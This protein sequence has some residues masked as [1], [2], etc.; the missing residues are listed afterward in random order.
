MENECH[1]LRLK[2]PDN[3]VLVEQIL[4]QFV[5]DLATI[6]NHY[7]LPSIIEQTNKNIQLHANLVNVTGGMLALDKFK[8]YY[9]ELFFDSEG[10]PHLHTMSDR[11][12]QI[13]VRD[14]LSGKLVPIKQLDP[15]TPHKNLGYLLVPDGDQTPMF[16]FILSHVQD[17][18]AK[19]TNSILWPHEITLSYRS[20]L[21]PQVRYRLAA[22][23][24]TYE[25][26]DFMMKLIYP[27]L[28]HASSLPST[29]P[30][31]IASAPFTYAGLGFEHFYDIQG[32]E[33]L[34]LFMMHLRRND[35]TGKMIY[36]ALQIMQQSVGSEKEFYDM[37]YNKYELYLPPSWLKH[38]C[39]YIHSRDVSFELTKKVAFTKQRMHDQFIMDV[40]T[41]YFTKTQLIQINKIRIHLKV[42]RLSDITDI[43]GKYILPNILRG[44]NFR[45][46]TYG[47]IRQ[48]IVKKFLPIWKQACKQMQHALNNRRLGRWINKSQSWKWTSNSSGTILS[49]GENTY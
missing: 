27:E 2:I 25:Q 1:G 34:P 6:C 37:D 31:S 3:T 33:K 15:T 28:L 23:S 9:C 30:R 5:D 18:Q 14:P 49:D 26:C 10:N 42:L 4:A 20:V 44:E 36:I 17:W 11:L 13:I 35:T 12:C 7:P 24:L 29:F 16:E 32:R 41:P 22:T 46:S 19:V 8:V 48:P 45:E 38:F 21:V 43:S 47:W 40:I 39:E